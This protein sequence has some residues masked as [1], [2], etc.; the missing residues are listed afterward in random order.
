MLVLEMA[1]EHNDSDGCVKV[2]HVI[3]GLEKGGAEG[4]LRRFIEYELNNKSKFY[5]CIVTLKG[6]GYHGEYLRKQGVP[7]FPLEISGPV[8][9]AIGFLKLICLLAKERPSIVQTWM[10]HSDLLGGIAARMASVPVIIWGIRTTDYS[11]ESYGS[12]I[13]RWFCSKLSSVIPSAIVCAAQ[14]SYDVSAK[15]GYDERKLTVIPNGFDLD[16]LQAYKGAG[17]AIR[18]R[19]GL[20]NGYLVVGCM[21]RYDPAKDHLNFIRSAS[22]IA[23][24]YPRVRFLMVGRGLDENNEELVSA[25]NL[26][27]CKDRFI[28]LGERSDPAACLDALDVF[29]LSSCTEGFPNVLG[30]A[31]ALGVPCVTTNVGDAAFLLGND[32]SV[33]PPRDP[34]ALAN[35]V[36]YLLDMTNTDRKQLGYRGQVRVESKFSMAVAAQR[37][38]NLYEDLLSHKTLS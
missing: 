32:C 11:V 16:S 30:E 38:S 18:N 23:A 3:V 6:V 9:I 17:V 1:E 29:V 36:S 10:V 2:F 27:L 19:I 7:V 13:V 20:D 31:M 21:G 15:F 28:L 25:L 33:V 35:A 8:S 12:R 26:T 37:F 34:A 5:H 24:K 4:M 14:A 22:L